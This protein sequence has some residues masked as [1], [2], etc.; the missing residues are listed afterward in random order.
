[1]PKR[2][3]RTGWVSLCN[4]VQSSGG[5]GERR[6]R[7]AWTEGKKQNCSR[8]RRFVLGQRSRKVCGMGEVREGGVMEECLRGNRHRGSA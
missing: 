4:R 3:V 6:R 5:G 8:C 2:N 1:M 7:G